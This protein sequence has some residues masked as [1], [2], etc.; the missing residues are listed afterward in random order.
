M[1][2]N[3]DQNNSEYGHFIRSVPLGFQT[4]RVT[5]KCVNEESSTER[6]S[7]LRQVKRIFSAVK[8]WDNAD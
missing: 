6:R 1:Q 8:T 7:Y 2:E 5:T 3:A 4:K